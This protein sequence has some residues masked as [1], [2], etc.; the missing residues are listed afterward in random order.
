VEAS[1]AAMARLVADNIK[2][3]GEY[4]DRQ[5]WQAAE[6]VINIHEITRS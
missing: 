3:T 2:S 6:K 1:P 4:V 5:P